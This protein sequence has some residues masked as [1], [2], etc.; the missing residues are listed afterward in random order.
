[1]TGAV[2]ALNLLTRAIGRQPEEL[3]RAGELSRPVVN[4]LVERR[5]LEA[6]SLPDREVRILDRKLGKSRVPPRQALSER[7]D[8][9][10]VFAS[11][12]ME[13]SS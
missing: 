11:T 1:M 12:Q 7:F 5:A 8:S 9:R 13:D 10:C 6:L 3:G 4:E 2:V